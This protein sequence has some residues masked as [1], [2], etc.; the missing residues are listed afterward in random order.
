MKLSGKC[1]LK[2][3][4]K[5]TWK[6]G[7]K[8]WF[9]IGLVLIFFL[10]M[11]FLIYMNLFASD[12]ILNFDGSNLMLHGVEM[13]KNK[14]IL[15]P[16]WVETTTLELDTAALLAIPFYG[17][18][19]N[20]LI[21]YGLSNLV[22]VLIYILVISDILKNTGH[23][24]TTTVLAMDLVWIPY[25]VGM[26]DYY[27]MLF[28][29]GSQYGIKVLI[30]LLILDLLLC[31]KERQKSV[32]TILLLG[33]LCVLVFVS[34]LSSGIYVLFSIVAPV[35]C[36]MVL[37]ILLDNGFVKYHKYHILMTALTV[38]A[39]GAGYAANVLLGISAHGNNMMLTNYQEMHSNVAAVL[40]SIFQV[41]GAL[42]AESTPV[43]S[44]TGIVYILKVIL[45]LALVVTFIIHLKKVF[46]RT[47]EISYGKYV[48]VL[49]LWNVFVFIFSETRYSLENVII[50]NRYYLIVLIPLMLLLAMQVENWLGQVQKAFRV[51]LSLAVFGGTLLLALGCDGLTMKQFDANSFHIK[52]IV[53][54]VNN[55]DIDVDSVILMHEPDTQGIYRLLDADHKYSAY[56]TEAGHLVV[57][58]YYKDYVNQLGDSNIILLYNWEKPED[59]LPEEI[60]STYTM[61]GEVDWF[62]IYYSDSNQFSSN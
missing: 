14:A 9:S 50:E 21:S 60:S 45:V 59:F 19:G 62:N 1:D 47:E 6:A 2:K 31:K 7:L 25:C 55:M 39:A 58:D 16:G 24:F 13:W 18:T 4:G 32:K 12:K 33:L 61:I 44:A 42:P 56:D 30:P 27:N 28:F 54:F 53:A 22:F 57:Y 34:G 26:I 20:V 10:Q 5:D 23:S 40:L 41:L 52:D 15:I 29:Q 46:E 37:D 17:I 36:V 38:V 51:V 35:I 3:L 49:C 43:L 11:A 8:N 48:A